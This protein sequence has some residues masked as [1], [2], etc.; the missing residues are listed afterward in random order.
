M[1][2]SSHWIAVLLLFA[3]FAAL[4]KSPAP[5]T[6]L[7]SIDGFRADYLA[8]GV[9]PHLS[10]LANGGATAAMRPS[11]PSITFPNHTAIVTGLRPDRNGIV[12][13]KFEDPAHPG[14]T[15]TM[16]S[17]E[18]FWWAESEPIWITAEKAGVRTATMFWPGSNVAHDGVRPHDW[19]L[20]AEDIS[21]K[22]RVDAIIDWLR[23]PAA[24][25]PQLLTLYFD[26]V[27]TAGHR[28]GPD[29]P[30][31][32]D[33]IRAVDS[34][35]GRLK[36]EID[37]LG[38]PANLV[39]VADHGMA[40]TAPDRVIKLYEVA[41][42]AD[43]R[44]IYGGAY[45]ALEPVPG[46]E[47]ALAAALLKPHPHMNC[48]RKGDL[49]PALH[50]GQNP[51]VPAF[52]CVV[53][54]GWLAIGTPPTPDKPITAGG[55]H[56]YDPANPAMDALFIAHGPAFRRGVMLEPFDNVAVYPLL[57][58]LIGVTPREND[59]ALATFQPA[60]SSGQ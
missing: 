7:I 46:H 11:W 55:A 50:Y 2:R 31:T 27:D 18:P 23:R 45:A 24:T 12:S 34:E 43:F 42:P 39:I 40:A 21:P 35:I 13:N 17:S 47:A 29:D 8:R 38:Q 26:S 41:N 5:V 10:A 48:A 6:I 57:A 19:M 60:L 54:I 16:A 37:A 20:Y 51:R 28:F 9:T 49:P 44:F 32:N 36:S 15:F 30:R 33:A 58:K 25:R 1:L 52:I 56:G 53:E 59:G 14:L 4:A 22:Q 3:P